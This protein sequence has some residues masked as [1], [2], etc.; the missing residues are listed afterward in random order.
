MSPCSS[1][2]VLLAFRRCSLTVFPGSHLF[3][4]ATASLLPV[5][6]ARVKWQPGYKTQRKWT[7]VRK[8][9]AHPHGLRGKANQTVQTAKTEKLNVGSQF[10]PPTP[11][12]A[13]TFLFLCLCLRLFSGPWFS[14]FPASSPHINERGFCSLTAFYPMGPP[15]SLSVFLDF[16]KPQP[17]A[18]TANITSQESPLLT[19]QTPSCLLT[20][21]PP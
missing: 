16:L 19:S 13:M 10:Q 2:L 21:S 12:N 6:P 18:V 5:Q 9:S 15:S 3:R 7:G 8:V 11:L 14:L 1:S 4:A 20:R 17:W